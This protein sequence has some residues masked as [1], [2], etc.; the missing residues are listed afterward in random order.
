MHHAHVL[1]P[2]QLY[3]LDMA[4]SAFSF[5]Q[6]PLKIAAPDSIDTRTYSN[7]LEMSLRW[8]SS[9]QVPHLDGFTDATSQVMMHFFLTNEPDKRIKRNL[10]F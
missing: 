3:Q 10:N 9:L 2:Y 5:V 4:S 6:Q 7:L 1:F 8:P